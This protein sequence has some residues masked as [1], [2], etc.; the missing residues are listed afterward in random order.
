MNEE[1][2]ELLEKLDDRIKF[3]EEEM[4]T[5]KE[6]VGYLGHAEYADYF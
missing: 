6:F 4:I 1:L 5:V 3:L 2:E